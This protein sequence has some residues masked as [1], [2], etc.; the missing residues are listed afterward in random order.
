VR[1]CLVSDCAGIDDLREIDQEMVDRL[2][3]QRFKI[4]KHGRPY[5]PGTIVRELIQPLTAVLNHAAA[6]DYCNEPAFE[7]PT[8]NDKRDRCGTDEECAAILKA[9]A[10][11]AAPIFLFDMYIGDRI[12]ET[13]DLVIEDVFLDKA[14]AVLRDTKNGTNRGITLHQQIVELLRTVI[15][16]RKT[17]AVFL[18]D[19]GLPYKTYPKTAWNEAYRRAGVVNF[20][21]H[22][23]RHTFGTNADEA[24]MTQRQR[25]VQMGHCN[26]SVNAR[27]VN[28]PDANLIAAINKTRIGTT[29]ITRSI[30]SGRNRA[31][32]SQWLTRQPDKRGVGGFSTALTKADLPARKQG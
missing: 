11:H 31:L 29:T 3:K 26:G 16:D 27:Y 4:N 13:I 1:P 30:T 14:W 22:D 9:S 6:R 21:L 19:D 15:G 8:Y 28:V 10:P 5:K 2:I 7:R 24:D 18:T 32:V 12:G 25:E 23:L 17:G 20:R